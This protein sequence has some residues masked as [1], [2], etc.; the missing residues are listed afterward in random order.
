[1]YGLSQGFKVERKEPPSVATSGSQQFTSLEGRYTI[2]LPQD[3]SSYQ[4]LSANTPAGKAT[5]EAYNW[6]MAEGQFS[7][8]YMDRSESVSEPTTA[9]IALDRI[10]DQTLAQL[11]GAKGKL[12][13]ENSIS[14]SG[15]IGREL[16][17]ELPNG[18]FIIRIYLVSNRIYQ[19]SVAVSQSQQEAGV[20]KVLD[21]FQLLTPA[22][23]ETALKKKIAESTPDPLP[24]EPAAKKL[25]SDAED[26]G[27]KG[28]V[29]IVTTEEEDL[30][31]TWVVGKRKPS[32]T[33][34]YN[35]QGNIVK[36]ELYD[37]RGNPMD[38]TVY[39]YI[40][41]DRVSQSKSIRYEYDP[42]PIMSRPGPAGSET[43]RDPRYSSKYKYKYDD[44]GNLTEKEMYLNDGKL[45][46][47]FVYKYK[48]SQKEESVYSSDGSL[49]QK[50]LSRLDV[51]ENVIERTDFNVKDNSVRN[52]Y[53]YTY[54][55]D[56]KGNWTK[57]V[58]NKWV[59][60]DDKTS[61]EPA[62]ITYRTI[63]YQ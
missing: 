58:T 10:R 2:S 50:Y 3:I 44:R 17:I 30:S 52:K 34:Y 37:Y 28:R 5:G 26:E 11:A 21:S 48:D 16:K 39:G 45:W 33:Y 51:K 40:D 12:I 61:F 27:L 1:M 19:L 9:N 46:M 43:K 41:G 42:P 24:Q 13:K 55:F 8:I 20:V 57:R 15:H 6:R 4:P 36:K 35:D 22:D 18:L 53:S 38:I 14:L 59:T 31:G 25:K 29:K 60:K 47:R 32:S 49:N 7:V 23:I 63:T 56:A 62:W 54:E